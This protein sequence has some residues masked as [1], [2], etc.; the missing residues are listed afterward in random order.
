M[1]EFGRVLINKTIRRRITAD[2]KLKEAATA[3][4]RYQKRRS[5]VTEVHSIVYN[6]I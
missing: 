5:A 2:E 6:E 4:I 1:G 3:T